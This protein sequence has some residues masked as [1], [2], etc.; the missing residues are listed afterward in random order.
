[1]MRQGEIT[2]ETSQRVLEYI[3]L[4]ELDLIALHS[5]HWARPFMEAIKQTEMYNEPF[6]VPEPDELIFEETWERGE[7]FRSGMV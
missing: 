3:K 2:D 7:R 6:H 5:A 1:M 4:G